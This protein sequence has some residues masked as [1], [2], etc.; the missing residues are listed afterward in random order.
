MLALQAEQKAIHKSNE[1]NNLPLSWDQT[2]NM[3]ITHK[4]GYSI[5]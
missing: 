2:R 4:V 3:R 1:G 5:K